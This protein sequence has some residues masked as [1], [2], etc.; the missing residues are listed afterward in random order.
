MLIIAHYEIVQDAR[1]EKFFSTWRNCE[2]PHKKKNKQKDLSYREKRRMY[3]G[4][5]MLGSWQRFW[6]TYWHDRE[7]R[8]VKLGR[9]VQE[10]NTEDYGVLK[11]LTHKL[12]IL[13]IQE[14]GGSLKGWRSL[15]ASGWTSPP[16]TSHLSSCLKSLWSQVCPALVALGPFP[17]SA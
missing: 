11:F 9:K 7:Q 8:V 16:L 13:L 2:R 4:V 14:E 5:R 6:K 12:E 1:R 10:Q 17:S 3:H 15:W